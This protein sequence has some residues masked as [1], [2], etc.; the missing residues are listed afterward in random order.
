MQRK[1]NKPTHVSKGNVFEDLGFSS[2]ESALLAL[3]VSL[4]IEIERAIKKERLTPKQVATVLDI[5]QPQVSDLLTGKIEKM[6]VDKLTK[7]LHRLGRS[8]E[9]KTKKIRKLQGT[10][11]A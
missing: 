3:K 9:F 2:E 11:V 5:Q 7:Y 1:T 4:H 8:V 6:T 10:E